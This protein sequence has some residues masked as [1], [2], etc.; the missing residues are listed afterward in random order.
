MQLT[1]LINSLK[2]DFGNYTSTLLKSFHN[3]PIEVNRRGSNGKSEQ[4]ILET[5]KFSILFSGVPEDL[6]WLIAGRDS[7]LTSRFLVYAFND[8]SEWEDMFGDEDVEDLLE[9]PALKLAERVM[10]Y[11]HDR[12]QFKFEGHQREIHRSVFTKLHK[13]NLA[14]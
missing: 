1:T 3:E 14:N 5:P 13:D 7:G 11:R 6:K 2:Q 9:E 4:L 12:T 8:V 10:A